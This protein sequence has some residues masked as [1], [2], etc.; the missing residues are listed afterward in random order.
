MGAKLAWKNRG[1]VALDAI[2]VWRAATKTGT[3]TKVATLAGDA[4]SYEDTTA[5]LNKVSYYSIVSVKGSGRTGTPVTA[6][7][8]FTNTGPGPKNLALGDWDFGY[9]G[10]V[11][12]LSQLP[13][14]TEL[15]TAIGT[16]ASGAANLTKFYKWI[17]NGKIIFIPD[18]TYAQMSINT[19]V[20][21]KVMR[22]VNDT[23]TPYLTIDKAGYGFT[24]RLPSFTNVLDNAPITAFDS[25]L[26]VSDWGAI[27]ATFTNIST[28]LPGVLYTYRY[29]DA[30]ITFITSG[31]VLTA[32]Y[33]TTTTINAMQ[34]SSY[35]QLLATAL[36][37]NY[38]VLFIYELNL[39]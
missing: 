14:F 3:L 19:L 36:T 30:A 22:P 7:G 37:S 28:T 39:S 20:S 23:T 8:Y 32:N 16:A 38:V 26:K 33:N 24:I 25:T 27:A 2:E 12:D 29:N 5:P 4:L 31:H 35:Q 9:F 15:G 6:I 21:A 13:N 18:S 17:V 1:T 11:T 34:W 10:E